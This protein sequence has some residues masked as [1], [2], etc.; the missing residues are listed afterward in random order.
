MSFERATRRFTLKRGQTIFLVIATLLALAAAFFLRYGLVEP[1]ELTLACDAGAESLQCLIRRVTVGIF[2]WFGFAIV[3]VAAALLGVLRPSFLLLLI[4]CVFGAFGLVLYNTT[5]TAI[6][7][8]LL[9][10]M[11]AR[12]R[13]EPDFAPER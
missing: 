6:G 9:P 5:S 4:A 7:V 13:P 1:R 8:S 2:L 11:F 3:T 10:L 12:P